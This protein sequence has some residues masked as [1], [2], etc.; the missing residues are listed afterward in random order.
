MQIKINTIIEYK[1]III[2]HLMNCYYE[3]LNAL[4]NDAH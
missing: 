1:F 2:T 3:I 4:D